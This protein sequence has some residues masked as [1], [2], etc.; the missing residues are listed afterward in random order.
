MSNVNYNP[1]QFHSGPAGSITAL[2]L[3]LVKLYA[4]LAEN[5]LEYAKN[6]IVVASQMGLAASIAD[7]E[8]GNAQAAGTRC[9]MGQAIASTVI[10]IASAAGTVYSGK[11]LNN[12]A[13]AAKGDLAKLEALHSK[14]Q[15]QFALKNS[16]LQLARRNA[17]PYQ[18]TSKDIKNR[19]AELK[20]GMHLTT[21]L[22]SGTPA[23]AESLNEQ[24]VPAI[25]TH[26]DFTTILESL[27]K[28]ISNKY[29]NI[30]ALTSK[31][32]QNKG[33]IDFATQI[34]TQSSSAFSEYWRA[35][36]QAAEG[37]ERAN[38]ALA[39]TSSSMANSALEN[40]RSQNSNY[41]G[42]IATVLQAL[43]AAASKTGA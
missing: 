11:D 22:G 20:A 26:E 18:A 40:Q 25:E 36:Y 29:E 15:E 1:N 3:D 12:Q 34:G 17:N 9:Q 32:Q 19:L 37:I 31:I 10:T 27:E 23:E 7:K 6:N 13:D 16:D 14:V 4:E 33:Y 24:A 43:T 5:N 28:Q 2:T 39:N 21:K 8:A 35:N 30:S 41:Y 38:A 42:M